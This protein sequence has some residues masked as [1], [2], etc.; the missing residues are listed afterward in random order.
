MIHFK[1]AIV[2]K[3]KLSYFLIL[4]FAALEISRN[5]LAII[6]SFLQLGVNFHKII[7]IIVPFYPHFLILS[8]SIIN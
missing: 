7:I 3:R 5:F 1:N 4:I 6:L 2:R 8:D